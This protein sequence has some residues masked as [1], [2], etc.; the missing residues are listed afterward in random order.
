[1][2]GFA[3][4]ER[5]VAKRWSR[6]KELIFL[7]VLQRTGNVTAATQQAELDRSQVYRRRN[8]D[9]DFR[10]K[11]RDAMAQ[12]LDYLEAYLWEKAMGNDPAAA[13]GGRPID[14]KIAIFLL[15]AHRPEIFGDGRKRQKDSGEVKQPS[16]RASLMRKLDRMAQNSTDED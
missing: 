3:M 6:K 2:G 10:D 1:M 14:D 13:E 9:A 4:G 8:M 7:R 11:W 15:K 12:A 5:G 16:P